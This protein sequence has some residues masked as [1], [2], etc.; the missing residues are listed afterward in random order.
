[1]Y[2]SWDQDNNYIYGAAIGLTPLIIIQSCKLL[3]CPI[4][5]PETVYQ[6]QRSMGKMFDK[7]NLTW[8]LP[9]DF[10]FY[11]MLR[12]HFC[13]IIPQYT[14]R[15]QVVFKIFVNNKTAVEE[16]N[17]FYGSRGSGYP[18]FKDY[19]V[20]VNDPY[21]KRSI[22]I[23]L[24]AVHPNRNSELYLDAYLNGLEVFKLSVDKTC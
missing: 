6:T 14:K 7:Y 9:V 17:L 23:F 3:K 22:Q 24:L 21:G 2:R 8:I 18:V 1:M 11:Y 13:N 5:A 10:R 16:A 15:S 12:L 19:I 20:F 4:T